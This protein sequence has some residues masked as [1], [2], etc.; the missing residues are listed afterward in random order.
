MFKDNIGSAICASGSNL[1]FEGLNFFTNNS[2]TNGGALSLG[3]DSLIAIQGDTQIY[4]YNNTAR[5]AGGA[6]YHAN[7][8]FCAFPWPQHECIILQ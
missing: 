3:S 6:I 1:I 5:Y 8:L 7:W 2:G 4:F